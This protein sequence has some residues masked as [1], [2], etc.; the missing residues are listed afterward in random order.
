VSD[1]HICQLTVNGTKPTQTSIIRNN[2]I[3][4]FQDGTY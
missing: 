2:N 1:T 4:L 3:T